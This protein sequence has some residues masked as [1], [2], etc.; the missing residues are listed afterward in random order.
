MNKPVI[1]QAMID[2]YDEYTHLTL[3]RRRFME[4][5]TALAGTAAA[6]AAIAPML[7]ANSAKAEIIAET[8]ERIKGEDITYPGGDGEMKGYLVKPAEMSGKL[9]A[10]IVIH[11]NRGLNPHIRDVARRMALEGFLALAPDFLSPEGGTPGDED[12]AREMIGA[13]DASATNANAVATVA[14]LKGH[15]EST[16]NV[17]AIGFCW[18]GGLVNRLAVNAPDLK[19]GVAYYGAQPKAEDV[20]KIKAALLLHYAGL[21]ERINAGIEAYRK[22][23]TENGKDATIHVYEGVNHA[24]NND[25]S[26]A[27]YDK[28]AADLAWQRTVEFLKAKLA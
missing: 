3:D 15:A 2:A 19:A 9:P 24:F 23:L 11:E 27:R 13:L 6:A 8:D 25:T 4:K 20:P 14:F 12:K 18:G 21:D 26:A 1:T 16:A 7:A 22:A 5:L 10:V 17:G 28:E